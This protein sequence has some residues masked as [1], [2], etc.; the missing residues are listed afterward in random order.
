MKMKRSGF[1]VAAFASIALLAGCATGPREGIPQHV[2]SV[3]TAQTVG[4]DGQIYLGTL[5]KSSDFKADGTAKVLADYDFT[6]ETAPCTVLSPDA[7]N[8]GKDASVSVVKKDGKSFY[9]ICRGVTKI[10]LEEKRL[11]L[12]GTKAECLTRYETYIRHP[13]KD[14][15]AAGS[16]CGGLIQSSPLSR[17]EVAYKEVFKR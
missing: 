2:D 11:F 13:N 6:T 9:F 4:A 5:I 8:F 16:L 10:D 14:L 3:P 7:K 15:E 12:A 17:T 1:L